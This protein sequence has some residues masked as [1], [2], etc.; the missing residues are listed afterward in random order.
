[1]AL[2]FPLSMGF[3]R[4]EHWVGLQFPSPGDLPDPGIKPTSPAL[5]MDS[6]LLSY[7][8]APSVL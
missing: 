2:Q 5:Q 3:L 4:Q 1:M 7:W 8:E 6:L